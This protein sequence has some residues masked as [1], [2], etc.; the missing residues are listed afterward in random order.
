M[1]FPAQCH[2]HTRGCLKAISFLM[3]DLQASIFIKFI[4]LNVK[5]I[6]LIG[7][8][9]VNVVREEVEVLGIFTISLITK[10]VL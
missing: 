1:Q 5:I 10:F 7:L 8:E 6:F 4:H 3:A 9:F 2:L